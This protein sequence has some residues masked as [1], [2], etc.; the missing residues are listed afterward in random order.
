MLLVV[1]LAFG[2]ARLLGLGA[3]SRFDFGVANCRGRLDLI[4]GWLK[5]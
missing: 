5:S 2:L 1:L 3:F 4:S